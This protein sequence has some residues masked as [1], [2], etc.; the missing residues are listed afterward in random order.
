MSETKRKRRQRRKF[1]RGFKAD[2]VKLCRS[3]NESIRDVAERLDLAESAVRAWV[4][5]AD[6][7]EQG[8]TSKALTTDEKVEMARLR[9]VVQQSF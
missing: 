3:G 2:V 4:K 8:G 6:V 7:D 5:Q 9:R 1:T